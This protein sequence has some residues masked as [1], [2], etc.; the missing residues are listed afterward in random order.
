MPGTLDRVRAGAFPPFGDEQGGEQGQDGREPVV[1]DRVIIGEAHPVLG[2]GPLRPGYPLCD[3][4]D[5]RL[6]AAG[7]LFRGEPGHHPQRQRDLGA[8]G[9]QRMAAHGDQPQPVVGYLRGCAPGGRLLRQ[10]A[11]DLPAESRP[12][13]LVLAGDQFKKARDLGARSAP[14]FDD[15]GLVLDGLGRYKEAV[16]AYS[17][18]LKLQPSGVAA[19]TVSAYLLLDRHKPLAAVGEFKRALNISPNYA[20]ALFGLGEA[21]RTAGDTAQAID[22]YKRFLEASPGSSDAPAARRQLRE[23]EAQP[24]RPTHSATAT[25]PAPGSAPPP[26]PQP[27]QPP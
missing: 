1:Q 15:N 8:R 17:E 13:V 20:Q 18:A 14:L 26:M 10:L 16:E 11:P 7:D 23:L 21:Y 25:V 3:R 9:Q 4:G 24:A 5:G 2:Q 12:A 22:A 19:V 6:E 27:T